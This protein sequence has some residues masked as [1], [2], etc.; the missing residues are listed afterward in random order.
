DELEQYDILL[1][2]QA[3]P[4]EEEAIALH[5][6]NAARTADG[7]YD[8]WVER[9]IVALGELMPVRYAKRELAEPEVAL[10]AQAVVA[11]AAEEEPR[12]ER[13][14]RR[15]DRDDREQAAV[16]G[17]ALPSAAAQAAHE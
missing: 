6:R 14:R 15:R 3:F 10:V 5:E 2:E 7:I 17:Q 9:S 12:E 16:E 13:R 11:A 1:E 4:F 8:E